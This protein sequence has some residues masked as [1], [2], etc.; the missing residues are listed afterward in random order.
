MSRQSVKRAVWRKIHQDIDHP[1]G[2]LF[3]EW[4]GGVL[5]GLFILGNV[6]WFLI[7]FFMN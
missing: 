6:I 3:P 4:V 7:E 5:F 2:G 1:K